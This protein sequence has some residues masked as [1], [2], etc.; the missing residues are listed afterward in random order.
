MQESGICIINF[1]ADSG[2]K[3]LPQ[4]CIKILEKKLTGPLCLGYYADV[5]YSQGGVKFPT[6]GN[7]WLY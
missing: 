7:P 1:L 4:R 5:F 2:I 3:S 6:G